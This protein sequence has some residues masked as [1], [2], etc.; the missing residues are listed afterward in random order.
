[1]ISTPPNKQV[2]FIYKVILESLFLFFLSSLTPPNIGV[3]VTLTLILFGTRIVIPPNIELALITQSSLIVAFL[4][5]Q[6]TPPNTALISQ[7]SN[8]SSLKS[9]F[10]SPKVA[11]YSLSFFLSF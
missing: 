7:P 2:A 4:K 1:M 9:N 8:F 6:L 11:E 5:S 10:C 3:E